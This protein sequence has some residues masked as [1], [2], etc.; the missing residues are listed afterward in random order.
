MLEIARLHDLDQT[1][2]HADWKD[3]SSAALG[4]VE[5]E[6]RYLFAGAN[7]ILALIG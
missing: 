5:A 1:D 2:G 6:K 7:R 4:R 3:S